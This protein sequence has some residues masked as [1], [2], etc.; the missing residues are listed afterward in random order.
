MKLATLLAVLFYDLS[1]EKIVRIP[2]GVERR[3]RE[4]LDLLKKNKRPVVLFVD[5][6]HDLNGHTLIGLKLLMELV[7]R[8][9]RNLKMIYSAQQW[10]KLAS[11]LKYSLWIA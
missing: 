1:T 3:E 4:F 6:A 5:E 11:G 2:T 10:K 9:T 8:V 7:E